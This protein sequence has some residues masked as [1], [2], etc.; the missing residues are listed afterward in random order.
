MT[1]K[2]MTFKTPWVLSYPNNQG[3][4]VIKPHWWYALIAD[5]DMHDRIIAL[6]E[7]RAKDAACFGGR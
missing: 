5:R 1:S 3:R 7:K 6:A 2:K 4:Y